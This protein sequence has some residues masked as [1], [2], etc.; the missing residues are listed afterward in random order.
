MV[1][2]EGEGGG[3]RGRCRWRRERVVFVVVEEGGADAGGCV[4][5]GSR[6]N[7]EISGSSPRQG[8]ETTEGDYEEHV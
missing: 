8:L 4:R 7:P 2:E 3:G 5:G 1:E 6:L